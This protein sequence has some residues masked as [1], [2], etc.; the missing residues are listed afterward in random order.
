MDV[1]NLLAKEVVATGHPLRPTELPDGVET[2]RLIHE[3]L[4]VQDHVSVS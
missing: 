4:E 2:L 3:R 1:P